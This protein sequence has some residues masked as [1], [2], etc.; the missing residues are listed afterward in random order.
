MSSLTGVTKVQSIR[1]SVDNTNGINGFFTITVDGETTEIIT[2]EA[3]ADSGESVFRISTFHTK[4]SEHWDHNAQTD[5][6]GPLL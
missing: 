5:A 3:K 6:A 2:C 4:V 1:R